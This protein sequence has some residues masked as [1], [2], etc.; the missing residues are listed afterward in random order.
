MGRLFAACC[1][2]IALLAGVADACTIIS[3]RAPGGDVW[4]GN[5]ED[6]AFDFDTYLN[7]LPRERGLLGVIAFTYTLPYD[8]P[9][10]FVQGGLNERGL[11]LDLNALPGIPTSE[12][13]DWD[14][15]KD[16]PGE[17]PAFVKHML[18]TCATVPEVL[19]LFETYRLPSLLGGQLH[20]A[21]RLGNLAIVNADG[22]CLTQTG[23]QISTNF[24]VCTQRSS[25]WAL[26]CWRFPIAERML[27]A[28]GVSLESFRAV[29]DSTQQRRGVSTVYTNIANLATGDI[30]FYY[31]G[32]FRKAYHFTI[33]DL[34]ARGKRSYLM[35]TLFRDAPIVT[36]RDA[37][38]A[39]G[40]AAAVRISE[41]MRDT[42]PEPARLAALRHIFCGALYRTSRF[43]DA[44]VFV[45]EWLG[46]GGRADPAAEFYEGLARLVT[47]DPE[48][49]RACLE[50]QAAADST[51]PVARR[52]YL[53]AVRTL[54]A[55]LNGDRP[56]A[57]NARFELE[58]Y[59]DARFVCVFGISRWSLFSFLARTADGWAG[60]FV[61]PPG[62]TPY[63]FL[64]DGRMIR[65]PANPDHEIISDQEGR[66]D[67]SIRTI[68]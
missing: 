68:E 43:A 11:F 44:R 64:V 52:A 26:T 19:A 5:N 55:R 63:A 46:T 1:L 22:V 40:A 33:Q 14:R 62:R 51:D 3:G 59:R 18:R 25:P 54:L 67:L 23:P 49:A 39:K 16:F 30:Y 31:A 66:R 58:G 20:V 47:G 48:G 36:I 2:L 32:D 29:M 17:D 35:R 27:A 57:A 37:C 28:R 13:R 60:D 24:N 42:L 10:A 50:R 34:L 65:D 38:Q 53:P 8:R 21:D 15:K 41:R 61:L 45:D 4:T 9:H 12:Y 6:Y 7:V 56:P